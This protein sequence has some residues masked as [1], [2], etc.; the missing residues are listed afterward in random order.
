MN[1]KDQTQQPKKITQD[2]ANKMKDFAQ[3]LDDVITH[4]VD[5]GEGLGQDS[6]ET[7]K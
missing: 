2:E 1:N 5:Y 7:K 4:V 3:S 6:E